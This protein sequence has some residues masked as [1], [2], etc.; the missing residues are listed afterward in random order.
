MDIGQRQAFDKCQGRFKQFVGLGRVAHDQ[1]ARQTK[2]REL[3]GEPF[4]WK[5][6]KTAME[7]RLGGIADA[8]RGSIVEDDRESFMKKLT[9]EGYWN[10]EATP[11]ENWK[12]AF[13]TS[14]GKFEFYSHAAEDRIHRMAAEKK[15]TA[16][17]FLKSLGK[18]GMQTV[19][20][21][22]AEAPNFTGSEAEFPFVLIPYKDITYSV[23]S[24]ANIPYL[25]ELSGLRKGLRSTESWQTWIEIHPQTAARM[26]LEQ[27]DAVH[28]ESVIGKAEGFVLLT[29]AAPE[30]TVLMELGKGHTQFGRFA[31]GKGTNAKNLLAPYSDSLSGLTSLTG[32]RVR[33]AKA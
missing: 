1:I 24:G 26:G 9:K 3:S 6:F 33:I 13:K 8:K 5:N 16:E 12:S 21:P 10:D 2:A 28:V 29:D 25:T 31:K 20:V 17:E 32:T 30:N 4:P 11:A 19:C 27:G 14:S 15:Q 22:H 18:D 23:G 7:D